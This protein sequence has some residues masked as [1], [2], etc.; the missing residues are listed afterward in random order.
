MLREQVF[1]DISNYP[2]PVNPDWQSAVAEYLEEVGATDL[3]APDAPKRKIQRTDAQLCAALEG[4]KRKE[5]EARAQA[6]HQA[7][8]ARLNDGTAVLR[9]KKERTPVLSKAVKSKTV[10]PAA[11]PKRK[12]A[13]R[14]SSKAAFDEAAAIERRVAMISTLKSGGKIEQIPQKQCEGG[15]AEYQTQYTDIRWIGRVKGLVIARIQRFRSKTSYFV[16]DDFERYELPEPISGYAEEKQKMLTALLSKKLVLASD[17]DSSAKVASRTIA[18]LAEIHDLDVYTV[19]ESR[20][21]HGWIFIMDEEK[22]QAKLKEVGDLLQA[23]DFLEERKLRK[24]NDRLPMHVPDVILDAAYRE[25]KR[26][27]KDAGATIEEVLA[28]KESQ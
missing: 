28:V 17:I 27:A 25:F 6:E 21:V 9:Q 16:L 23:L 20:S 24:E 5:A 2:K 13:K 15:Y 7:A 19:F 8:L 18:A 12:Y 10:R 11:A 26:V 14:N 4:Q 3:D 22:R 1:S